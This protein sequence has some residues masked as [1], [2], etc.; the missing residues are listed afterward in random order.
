LLDNDNFYQYPS[1][2]YKEIFENNSESGL[3]SEKEIKDF[4]LKNRIPYFNQNNKEA[5]KN[6]LLTLGMTADR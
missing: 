1:T 6:L 2:K 3:F 4:I 5:A